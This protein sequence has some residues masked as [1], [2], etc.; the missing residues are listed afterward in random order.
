MR[1]LTVGSSGQDV[2][3]VQCALAASGIYSGDFDGCFG[4]RTQTAVVA[5]QERAGLNADGVVDETTAA[6]IG[7]VDTAPVTCQVDAVTAEMVAPMF[8]G[9]P[10]ANIEANLPY[11]LNALAEA[12]LCDKAMLLMALATIRAETAPFLPIGELQ[13]CFNTSPGG[14]PFDL[15]DNRAELGNQGPPDGAAF[16]GRGFVQLTG[17]ANYQTFGQTIGQQLIDNP[18][19]AHRP[20]IAAKLLA[21][22]LKAHEDKIRAALA[23]NNLAEARKLVNGGSSGLGQFEDAFNA[24]LKLIPDLPTGAKAASG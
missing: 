14:H 6:A 7:I 16:R 22:F 15:Y 2:L 8:P 24:G 23:A 17:R 10:V 19:I 20:D 21:S 5:F 1:T 4:P 13:S 18:L 11:V 3:N 12:G 9:T